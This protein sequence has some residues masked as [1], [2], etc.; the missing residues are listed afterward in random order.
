L[1]EQTMAQPHPEFSKPAAAVAGRDLAACATSITLL[2]GAILAWTDMFVFS[3]VLHAPSWALNPLP[4]FTMPGWIALV[5]LVPAAFATS[6][7][8]TATA[9]TALAAVFAPL[10]ALLVRAVADPAFSSGDVL[11]NWMWIVA[12]HATLPAS[13]LVIARVMGSWV[14]GRD[15]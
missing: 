5:C 7:P 9:G 1:K 12:W 8:L 2:A 4:P 6:R 10:L 14:I 13:A 3:K 11:G 15:S